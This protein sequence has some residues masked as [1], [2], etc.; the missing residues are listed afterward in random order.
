MAHD[1]ASRFKSHIKHMHEEFHISMHLRRRVRLHVAA[2]RI[3]VSRAVLQ[4]RVVEA[5]ATGVH[6]LENLSLQEPP[7]VFVLPWTL[8]SLKRHGSLRGDK[9]VKPMQVLKN[10]GSKLE[11]SLHDLVPLL[12]THMLCERPSPSQTARDL[13]VCAVCAGGWIMV[14]ARGRLRSRRHTL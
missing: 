7:K 14:L 11:I 12:K 5:P 2:A 9:A 1:T 6:H 10:Y 4:E 3:P 13:Q 8:T